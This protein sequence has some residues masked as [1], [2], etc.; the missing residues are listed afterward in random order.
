MTIHHGRSDGAA[1]ITVT[2]PPGRHPRHHAGQ[3]SGQRDLVRFVGATPQG[4]RGRRCRPAV[5]AVIITG[6]GGLFSFGADIND[7]RDRSDVRTR[8]ARD[9]MAALERS[10]KTFVAAID[11]NALGG[12]RSWRWRA[13]TGSARRKRKSGFPEI[14]LGLLP[15]GGGTQRLPRLIG[16]QDALALMLKG[17]NVVAEEALKKGHSRRDRRAAT[18]STRRSR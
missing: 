2:R 3:S 9:V 8:N 1:L 5:R 14:R 15:G 12:G 4:G 16:A 13:T 10:E 18:S 6:A 17:D 7:F 11:G